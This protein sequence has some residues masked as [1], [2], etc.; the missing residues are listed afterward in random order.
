MHLRPL[1]AQSI[2]EFNE[3][4][5]AQPVDKFRNLQQVTI[6]SSQQ[7]K[8]R[9]NHKE[10][11]ANELSRKEIYDIANDYVDGLISSQRQY[12]NGEIGILD[13]TD[14]S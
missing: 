3:L 9:E 10:K 13:F 8:Q 7:A 2:L 12:I 14:P 6:T 4:E 1:T 11:L 5:Q